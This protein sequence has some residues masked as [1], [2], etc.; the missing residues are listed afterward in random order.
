MAERF[1][2]DRER[3]LLR[4]MMRRHEVVR[5]GTSSNLEARQLDLLGERP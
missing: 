4:R 5:N 2:G 1:G 3:D